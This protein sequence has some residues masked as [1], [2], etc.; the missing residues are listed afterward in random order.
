MI[1]LVL[2]LMLVAPA[3]QPV[4]CIDSTDEM[5]ILFYPDIHVCPDKTLTKE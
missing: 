4:D 1:A 3:P 2:F 5:L